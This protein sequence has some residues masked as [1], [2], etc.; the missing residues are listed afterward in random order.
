V[1]TIHDL[2][3]VYYPEEFLKRD[4]HKL[5]HWTKYSVEKAKK[6]IC[7]SE[8]TK[9]D[10]VKCY[11][12]EEK[13]IRVIYNG[14]GKKAPS[15]KLQAPNSLKPYILYVGTLQPRKNINTLIRAFS[16]FEKS[17][18]RYKLKIVGKKGWMYEDIYGLVKEL[19]LERDVMFEGYVSETELASLYQNAFCFVLPSFYEGF[20]IPILEAM[21]YQCPVIAS[22]T[23]SLPGIGGNACL[24]FDPKNTHQLVEK[25]KEIQNET[26]RKG[27]IEKGN[28]RIK[29]FSWE[30]CAK[31]TLEVLTASV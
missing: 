11:N 4:L 7:V 24:Y 26:V 21:S 19:K 2:S 22:N 8:N 20:G 15:S 28:E 31:E 27:L 17:N 18:P 5:T 6:I 23:S 29:H 14:F 1:V 12:V 10:L 16:E 25:L 30:K 9:K 13:K 3:Y